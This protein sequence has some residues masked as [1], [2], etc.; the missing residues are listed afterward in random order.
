MATSSSSDSMEVFWKEF[1]MGR[2]QWPITLWSFA[3]FI[4]GIIA[5]LIGIQA[6]YWAAI[7]TGWE[8]ME[9]SHLGLDC[10]GLLGS[11][12][13]NMCGIQLWDDYRGGDSLQNSVMDIVFGVLGWWS[14]QY[15]YEW[16]QGKRKK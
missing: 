16:G 12:I 11:G 5:W 15:V 7:C 8:L 1:V 2:E 13:T 14:A 9:N 6:W 10:M 3:H 4:V